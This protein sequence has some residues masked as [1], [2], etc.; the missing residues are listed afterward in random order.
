MRVKKLYIRNLKNSA[1][2]SHKPVG[3]FSNYG[4]VKSLNIIKGKDFGFIEM[5]NIEE[6]DKA[7]RILNNSYFEGQLLKIAKAWPLRDNR[8]IDN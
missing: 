6:A 1:D 7:Q 2:N 3:L 8:I 4:T 5:T